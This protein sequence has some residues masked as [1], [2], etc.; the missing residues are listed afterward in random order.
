MN[1][2]VPG[3]IVFAHAFA[4]ARPAG[5]SARFDA[6]AGFRTEAKP[7]QRAIDTRAKLP[8]IINIVG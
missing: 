4:P 5:G 7:N 1:G 3:V 8:R 2:R 6:Q